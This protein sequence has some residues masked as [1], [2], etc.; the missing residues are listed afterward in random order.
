MDLRGYHLRSTTSMFSKWTKY[1][2]GTGGPWSFGCGA[3]R[4]ESVARRH[5]DRTLERS[6][7]LGVA[8]PGVPFEP[9][10]GDLWLN[11]ESVRTAS[12]TAK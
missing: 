6:G 10:P 7:L 12:L 2:V 11:P 9:A 3:L 4:Q 5:Q 8:A 1:S